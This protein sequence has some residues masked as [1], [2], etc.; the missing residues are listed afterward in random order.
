[1]LEIKKKNRGKIELEREIVKKSGKIKLWESLDGLTFEI[2]CNQVRC[3]KLFYINLNKVQL[4]L[5][6]N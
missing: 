5:K 3:L 6:K 4:T 2:F 1:M